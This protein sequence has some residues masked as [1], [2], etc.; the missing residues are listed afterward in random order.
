MK[1]GLI[2]Q[3]DIHVKVMNKLIPKFNIDFN[4]SYI[5]SKVKVK[6]VRK[7]LTPMDKFVIY[8]VDIVVS[9][10]VFN[11]GIKPTPA[12]FEYYYKKCYNTSLRFRLSDKVVPLLNLIDS[13]AY[14]VKISKIEYNF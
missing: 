3:R 7:Y 2:L 11:N 9:D 6:R 5:E 13:M 10:L 12:E 14:E 4:R 1:D 8:E